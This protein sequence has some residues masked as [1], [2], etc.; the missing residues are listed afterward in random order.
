MGA[1]SLLSIV[2]YWKSGG[3]SQSLCAASQLSRS[4]WMYVRTCVCV[5]K[6]W[7]EKL[8]GEKSDQVAQWKKWEKKI[9]HRGR[10]EVKKNHSPSA[11]PTHLYW[12]MQWVGGI[13]CSNS[14]IPANGPS[15]CHCYFNTPLALTLLT[16]FDLWFLVLARQRQWN[17]RRLFERNEPRSAFA[18]VKLLR[19]REKRRSWNSHWE[20]YTRRSTLN[21]D[22]VVLCTPWFLH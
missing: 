15:P 5:C 17:S 21:S 18:Q 16:L 19:I 1:K 22:K 8:G 11:S 9:W 6:R 4:A 2:L 7:S 10:K 13:L 20:K 12:M 3:T 14:V